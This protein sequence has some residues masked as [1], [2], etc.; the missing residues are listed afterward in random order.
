M[1][2][3]SASEPATSRVVVLMAAYNASGTVRE[4]VT[5]ILD[6]TLAADLLVI[7]DCSAEPVAEV[8]ADLLVAHPDRLRVM[9]MATNSRQSSCLNAGLFSVLPRGYDFVALMDADDVALP[10]RLATQAAFL[11]AHPEVGACGSWM[12]TFDETTLQPMYVHR[13]PTDDEAIRAAMYFNSAVVHPSMM[14][15]AEVFRLMGGYN[16]ALQAAEDYELWRRIQTRWK[17]ANIPEVLLR[18]RLSS[19]GQSMAGRR[20]QLGIRLRVQLLYFRPSAWRAWA[21]VALTLG[22]FVVPLRVLIAAKAALWK[23]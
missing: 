13:H 22:L 10:A 8:L 16:P 7:D 9:R 19:K 14:V 5:S 15:R 21:G 4:A 11:D 6:N 23:D 1:N 17:L 3:R 20:R 18:Y 12:Q 2:Y